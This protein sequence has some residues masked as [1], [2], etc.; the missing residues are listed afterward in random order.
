MKRTIPVLVLA[1]CASMGFAAGE[2]ATAGSIL[3]G[4][5]IVGGVG[6]LTFGAALLYGI[7]YIVDQYVVLSKLN[8][9]SMEHFA[10]KLGEKLDSVSQSNAEANMNLRGLATLAMDVR[11][12]T[13]EIRK[14]GEKVTILTS[15]VNDISHN[16]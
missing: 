5:G 2:G 13:D 3:D 4:A 14:V 16:K 10:E 9:D 7:K 15:M 12:N 11:N 6:G 1:G 8:R